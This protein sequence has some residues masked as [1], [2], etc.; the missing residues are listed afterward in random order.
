MTVAFESTP[1][2]IEY[3]YDEAFDLE[4]ATAMTIHKSQGSEF[5]IV[6][7]PVFG[8]MAFFL[9]RN[10]FYTAITRASEHVVVVTDDDRSQSTR[11]GVVAAIRTEDTSKRNTLLGR[12]I[13]NTMTEAQYA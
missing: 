7:V 1:E 4:P 10:L 3:D 8:S 6:I 12:M 11:N 2:P 13:S 5:P 9:R